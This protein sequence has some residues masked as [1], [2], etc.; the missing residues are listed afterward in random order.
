MARRERDERRVPHGFELESSFAV[1]PDTDE[2]EPHAAGLAWHPDGETLVAQTA[3]GLWY[4]GAGDNGFSI[5][6]SYDP[7]LNSVAFS[8]DG[9][10]IVAGSREG[11]LL[12]DFHSG[13]EVSRL[14]TD[15]REPLIEDAAWSPD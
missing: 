12:V 1:S 11:V 10:T 7:E 6:Y 9:D 8:P 2:A 13:D 3:H 5:G 15:R 4:C 14:V